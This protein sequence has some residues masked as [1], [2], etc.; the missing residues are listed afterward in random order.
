VS[1]AAAQS[2]SVPWHSPLAKAFKAGLY[3]ACHAFI[4]AMTIVGVSMIHALL[5]LVGNP[6]LFGALPVSYIFDVMDVAI[7][8]MFLISG[9]KAAICVFRE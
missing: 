1:E 2:D 8:V 7:L 9:T 3:L 4:A 5:D 6:K